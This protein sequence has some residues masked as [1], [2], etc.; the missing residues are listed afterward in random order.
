MSAIV[1]EGELVHRLLQKQNAAVHS[2]S[3]LQHSSHT[4]T[5]SGRAPNYPLLEMSG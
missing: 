5:P 3:A 4:K 2:K 1:S